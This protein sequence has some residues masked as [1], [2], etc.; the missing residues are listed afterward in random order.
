MSFGN[1]GYPEMLTNQVA[2]ALVFIGVG[3]GNVIGPYAFFESQAP[4]YTT[5]VIVCMI[6]R[7]AEVCSPSFEDACEKADKS[8][9]VVILVLR[10]AFAIPNKQRDKKFAEGDRDYD[11]NVIT[12]EDMTDKQNLHF[13]Y[14]S[15]LA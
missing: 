3:L 1:S 8:Q 6:S 11:P 9:I 10:L 12:Y 14:L 13:R 5:G 15:K 4:H 2:S 7:I